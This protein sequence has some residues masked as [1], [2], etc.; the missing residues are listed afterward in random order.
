MAIF[1]SSDMH[2]GHTN[3]IK[4]CNRPFNNSKEISCKERLK[5]NGCPSYIFCTDKMNN[6]LIHNW[7][8]R[9]NPEDTIIHLGD[10]CFKGGLEGGDNKAFYW[11]EKLNGTIVHVKGNHDN[12]NSVKTIITNII[13]EFGNKVVMGVH[14]PP[15]MILEIPEFCDFV[16]CGH[17]HEQW[18][19]KWIN[20]DNSFNRDP[21][22][23]INVG[24]D[25]WKFAPVKLEEILKYYDFVIKNDKYKF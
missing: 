24:V 18:K 12:N 16:L 13:M 6:I 11:Q 3:I 8:Q 10:F 2:L 25:V 21:I 7:N 19:H 4:Y 14:I 17:V 20:E 5:C 9:V 1:F 15:S 22:L 23:L